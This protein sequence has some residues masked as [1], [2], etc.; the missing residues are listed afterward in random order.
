MTLVPALIR[1]EVNLFFLF[2]LA[3]YVSWG[4][5]FLHPLPSPATGFLA[6]GGLACGPSY[7]HSLFQFNHLLL[8]LIYYNF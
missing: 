6:C 5:L 8:T 3:N 7:V 4:L 2:T 1:I